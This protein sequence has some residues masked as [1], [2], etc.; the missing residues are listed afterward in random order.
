MRQDLHQ[1]SDLQRYPIGLKY[2]ISDPLDLRGF[3]YGQAGNQQIPDVGSH[4]SQTQHCLWAVVA[5]TPVGSYTV[6]VTVAATD[7][8][9]GN[10][11]IGEDELAGGYCLLTPHVANHVMHRMIK[12]NTAVAAPGGAM[13]IRLDRPTD[14]ILELVSHAECMANPYLLLQQGGLGNLGRQPI[15]GLPM[16]GAAVNQFLWYQTWGPTWV[17]P[18]GTVGVAVHNVQVVFRNDGS[19]QRHDPADA[20]AMY[21]QHAGFVMTIPSVTHATPAGQAAPFIFLQITP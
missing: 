15:M 1:L 10:G 14:Y 16:V 12:G 11:A 21:Q 3:R 17:A 4:I 2:P 9:A 7:G 19:I 20:M 5:D 6:V 8:A 13:T 18:Q